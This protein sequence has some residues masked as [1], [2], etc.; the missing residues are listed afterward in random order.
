MTNDGPFTN[1]TLLPTLA[2][3]PE[4][5]RVLEEWQEDYD[6]NIEAAV[7][8][9]PPLWPF[10][11]EYGIRQVADDVALRFR[12]HRE[13][14]PER[15]RMSLAAFVE[16]YIERVR[17]DAGP[18]A[19]PAVLWREHVSRL[20]PSIEV[21]EPEASG[22]SRHLRCYDPCCLDNPHAEMVLVVHEQIIGGTSFDRRGQ[23]SSWGPAGDSSGHPTRSAA[24]VAN[25]SP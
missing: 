19:T 1:G 21:A 15:Q 17:A 9:A 2:Y 13:R 20:D 22:V 10:L 14:T 7:R 25:C 23:W 8:V 5:A 6:W 18:G 12:Q 4:R 24:E 11:D 16:R 3:C